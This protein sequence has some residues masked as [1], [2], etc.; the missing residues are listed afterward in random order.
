M[1]QPESHGRGHINQGAL[2]WLMY[3]MSLV[4]R[5]LDSPPL[6]PGATD[7]LVGNCPAFYCFNLFQCFIIKETLTEPCLYDEL[8][9]A[10]I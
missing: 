3:L 5:T 1:D 7:E 8:A 9:M 6:L 4:I 10:N 2:S